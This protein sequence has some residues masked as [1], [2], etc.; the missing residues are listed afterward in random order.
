MQKVL[1]KKFINRATTPFLNFSPLKPASADFLKK[2]FPKKSKKIQK[3]FFQALCLKISKKIQKKIF[4]S[5]LTKKFPKKKSAEAGKIFYLKTIILE[6]KMFN[7]DIIPTA[8]SENVFK[9]LF[10]RNFLTFK[11]IFIRLS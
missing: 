11:K 8:I 9:C 3:I 7:I 2:F 5:T 4:P 10:A 1:F 6:I